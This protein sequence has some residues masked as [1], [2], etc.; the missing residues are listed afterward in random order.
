MK[1]TVRHV[2]DKILMDLGSRTSTVIMSPLDAATLACEIVECVRLASMEPAERRLGTEYWC[3]VT[4]RGKKVVLTARSGN[5]IGNLVM[6]S[7][8][9]AR[10]I[11]DLLQTNANF[12]GHGLR[13]EVG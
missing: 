6:M 10:N 13:I 4:S 9:A 11:A 2:G 7:Q 8:P 12:A 3:G 5:G 1:P